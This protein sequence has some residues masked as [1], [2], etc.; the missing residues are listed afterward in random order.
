MFSRSFSDYSFRLLRLCCHTVLLFT[1]IDCIS[2]IFLHLLRCS[3]HLV[4]LSSSTSGFSFFC[5]SF[6]FSPKN[7][8]R[9][10]TSKISF[11]R[12][13]KRKTPPSIH[14][15]FFSSEQNYTREND[16][17]I[18]LEGTRANGIAHLTFEHHHCLSADTCKQPIKVSAIR[19]RHLISVRVNLCSE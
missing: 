19:R 17:R 10:R 8:N 1:S 14:I 11:E 7:M 6:F 12:R 4:S 9:K 3:K 13:R 5:F 18:V 16:R 2:A 15:Y